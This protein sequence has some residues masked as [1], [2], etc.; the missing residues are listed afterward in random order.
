MAVRIQQSPPKGISRIDESAVSGCTY[1]KLAVQGRTFYTEA[2]DHFGC[3]IGSH[4]HGI[5]LPEKVT[6]EL[7]GLVATMVE[8]E[9]I[10]MEEVPG[11]PQIEGPFGVAIYAPLPNADFEPDAVLVSG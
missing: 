2:A 4:V 5:D 11:I 9:Y 7:Q 6:G 1:W 10:G 8:L 3:P